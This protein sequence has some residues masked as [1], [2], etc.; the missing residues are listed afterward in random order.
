MDTTPK[1]RAEGHGRA[2]VQ[3]RAIAKRE[4]LLLGAAAVFDEVGYA[5]ASLSMIERRSGV[6]RGAMYFQ[7][8]T[9]REIADAVIDEQHATSSRLVVAAAGTGAG[10]VE[11]IVMMCHGLAAQIVDD[12]VVRGGIRL[13]MELAFDDEGPVRPYVG[14]IDVMA[15]LLG[16]AQACG[17]VRSEIVAVDAARV[18][19]S[20]FTGT[21]LVSHVLDRRADLSRRVDDL[22]RIFLAGIM[23]DAR[24]E[25]I[26]DVLAARC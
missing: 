17:D 5:A 3:S 6:S 2:V 21:Q 14:W 26:D 15:D 25:R 16:R 13:T 8:T 20:A 9:K 22:L 11:Q 19:V 4:Q 7:F 24:R 12:P 18:L 1:L 23:T 10:P